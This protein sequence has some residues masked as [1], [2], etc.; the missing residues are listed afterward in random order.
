VGLKFRDD[1]EGQ[2][3]PSRHVDDNKDTMPVNFF[4]WQIADKTD[5]LR[6]IS[7]ETRQSASIQMVHYTLTK[8]KDQNRQR[9]N[10]T[11]PFPSRKDVQ[12]SRI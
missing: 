10:S 6:F 8:R 7:V 9:R 3:S 4:P 5:K 11:R 12:L 2:S 1:P